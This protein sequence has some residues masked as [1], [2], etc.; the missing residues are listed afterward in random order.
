MAHL[1]ACPWPRHSPWGRFGRSGCTASPRNGHQDRHVG[2]ALGSAGHMDGHHRKP[3][4][5]ILSE[6]TVG[7]GLLQILVGRC[8]HAHIHRDVLVGTD[9]GNLVLLQGTQDLGLAWRSCLRFHR[10]TTCHLEP[11]QTCPCVRHGAGE[12]PL[13]VA[14]Q[15]ALDQLP[16]DGR[17]VDFHKRPLGTGRPLCIWRATNSLPPVCPGDQHPSFGGRDGLHHAQD[18]PNGLG[19]PTMVWIGPCGPSSSRLGWSP[20][21]PHAP[22]CSKRDQHAVQVQRLLD[23]I[24]RAF[25]RRPRPCLPSHAQRS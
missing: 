22:A 16:W 6:F 2:H 13:L 3:V 1:R 25:F 18:L 15:L 19:L 24:V 14:K 21:A 7:D 10:G 11:A 20:R 12:R 4:V 9:A 23:E 5:Q 8:H 17:T